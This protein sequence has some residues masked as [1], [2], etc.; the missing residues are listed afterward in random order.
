MK[1]RV[2]IFHLNGRA[3][4]WWEHLRQVK[5]ISER[6]ITWKQ[7]KKHFKHKYLYD[8]YYDDK[9]KKFHELRLGKQTMDEY[10][11]K[12]LKLLRYV[13]YIRDEKLRSNTF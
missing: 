12:F 6:K 10:A 11:N 1:S 4:I 9:I 8:R 7:F 3:S 2:S 13:R 5:N